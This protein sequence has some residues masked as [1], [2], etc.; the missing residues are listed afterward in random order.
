MNQSTCPKILS[1]NHFIHFKSVKICDSK[2][3]NPKLQANQY[4]G[5]T[6][7]FGGYPCWA[8]IATTVYMN[9]PEVNILK[10]NN[11]QI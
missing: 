11:I 5:W 10:L 1:Y 3:V 4:P 7:P 2:K 6:D 9:R 8:E